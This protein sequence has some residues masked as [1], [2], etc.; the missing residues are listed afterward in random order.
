MIV[1]QYL[2]KVSKHCD[3]SKITKIKSYWG[4][5]AAYEYNKEGVLQRITNKNSLFAQMRGKS[6]KK[7]FDI[8]LAQDRRELMYEKINQAYKQVA[9]SRGIESATDINFENMP[10]KCTLDKFTVDKGTIKYNKNDLNTIEITGG[11]VSPDIL[12]NKINIKARSATLNETLQNIGHEQ[13]HIEQN[14]MM[15]IAEDLLDKNSE[16]TL[17]FTKDFLKGKKIKKGTLEWNKAKE[18]YDALKDYPK[19]IT[20]NFELYKNNLLEVDAKQIGET[21]IA[22]QITE[23]LRSNLG[24]DAAKTLTWNSA[25]YNP[26]KDIIIVDSLPLTKNYSKR[27][28]NI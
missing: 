12:A 7:R 27:K 23:K 4:G 28:K 1:S 11:Y 9:K 22:K 13:R 14:Q 3:G 21:E 5:T 17:A 15:A 20:N 10:S 6:W 25:N 26:T 24:I 19:E 2:I 16:I 18:F 8:L